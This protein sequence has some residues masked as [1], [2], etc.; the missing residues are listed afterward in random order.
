M[1]I[2]AQLTKEVASSPKVQLLKST[3]MMMDTVGAGAS[4]TRQQQSLGQL[5]ALL[6]KQF[7][8]RVPMVASSSPFVTV[9][10]GGH[11]QAM[12]SSPIFAGGFA[13]TGTKQLFG[14]VDLGS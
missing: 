7:S 4:A 12:A 8:A 13:P 9:S 2:S 6:A 14:G 10:D 5:Q 11:A 1:Q 3:Q